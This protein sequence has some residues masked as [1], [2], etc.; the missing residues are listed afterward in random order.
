MKN[1]HFLKASSP[2]CSFLLFYFLP[3]HLFAQSGTLRGTVRDEAG[4][5]IPGVTITQKG[6]NNATTSG[7][8][9]TF[10]LNAPNRSVLIFSH[11]G[12][13]SRELSVATGTNV[14][15]SLPNRAANLNEVVVIGYGRQQRRDL[16]GSVSTVP[17]ARLKDLPVS[18]VDQKL[19]GQVPGLRITSP[20]GAPGGGTEIKIR[21]S[22]SIGAGDN[23]LFVV[24][25]YPLSIGT[26]QTFNPLNI[27][28]PDDIESI[29]VLKDASSTAIY[30]SRGANG[31]IV[32]TTRRGRAGAPSLSI[33]SYTGIEQVP[34]K[35]RPQ[36]LNA[37][38]YAQFRKDMIGDAFAARGQQATDNDIPAPFRD[39]SQYGEGTNWYNE[40]LQTAPVHNIDLNLSGGSENTR[41]SFSAGH[42]SQEGV[43]RY[44]DFKRYSLRANVESSLSSKFKL[45]LTLSPSAIVQNRGDFNTGFR[46]IMT[47]AL[48]LSPLVPLTDSAGKR[49]VFITSPGAI[50]AGNPLNTLEFARTKAKYFR[51]LVNAF[52]ELEII[53]GLRARYSFNVD[54]TNSGSFNFSPSFVIGETGNQNPNLSIPGSNT[55]NSTTL[56]WLSE[57][58]VNYD[59]SIG[60]DHRIN[61]LVGY[62]AQKDRSEGYSFNA[63][64][65]AD[66]LITTINGSTLLRSPGAFVE[67]WSLLSYLARANYA[68]KD[69]YLFTA[70]I[71]TDGSSRFGANKRYG[72]FPSA[73]IGWRISEENFM[74]NTTW[75]NSLKL[76][77]SYGR[78]GNFNIGN[79]A[80][81][82]GI[83]STNYAFGGQLAAGRV[84]T[85]ISNQDL[86]WETSDELDL[87]LDLAIL[88]NRL[89]FTADYYNRI[90]TGMLFSNDIPF[91]SGFGSITVNQGKVRNRGIELGITSNNLTG[92]LTWNSNFNITFNRNVV[93][94][95]NEKNDPIYSGRSGEGNST[96]KTEVGKPIGQFFGYVFQGLYRDSADLAKSPRH[97]SSVVG[98]VKYK[99]V[100]GDGVI[101]PFTD[102]AVIGNAQPNFT[103][104]LTNTFGYK[105]FDLNVII[106]GVQGGQIMKTANEFLMNID[107]VFN[108]D[109]KVLNRWRS[110]KNPGN[111][112]VPTTNG[113]RVIY[114]DV[115]STWIEDAGYLRIQNV[116]LGYN[117]NKGLLSNT[118]VIK[119]AR[120]Y[121]SVQNLAIFTNYSGS[122]P[123]AS[124]SGS[125]V[126]TPGRD[127]TNYPLPRIVTFGLNMNF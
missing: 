45:G 27:I 36:V 97:N 117:F 75:I 20:T 76:R 77:A 67:K 11:V 91:S 63:T 78:S 86:T 44:T 57:L 100:N 113:A 114:R 59:K 94:Q 42:L 116:A 115:N 96:H 126:L 101:L 34:Q 17:A 87:G 122:N 90:T 14:D 127:F 121:A 80:Y 52:A 16:T 51:G 66:N 38:E 35:G 55:A 102:F 31:V 72:T 47:R 53:T 7:D 103:Y 120:L 95:L 105:G 71:R 118:R 30:G 49:T 108:V 26:G 19:I 64:N 60:N 61:A 84:S 73:A 22:G 10:T 99:D 98:S 68:F 112:M 40:V 125:S 124:T 5:P 83:G 119:G 54:Y 33:N 1:L 62:T 32:I 4:Q 110:E 104:G 58:T 39:P 3:L 111:G 18:S 37:R 8:D 107:G 21:G 89:N 9:G 56:N 23:P 93:L 6:T 29:T 28:N 82:S 106:V 24:D 12:H 50:G 109:R 25:G 2:L 81:S 43:I 92:A 41:Y 123:E 48:W 74:R 15:V 65:Y 69:K 13:E 88:R 46:D 70:T 85:S 79:Y